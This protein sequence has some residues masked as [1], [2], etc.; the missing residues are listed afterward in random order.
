MIGS[1]K[2]DPGIEPTTFGPGVRTA[3]VD[4]TYCISWKSS[5][6]W[7]AGGSWWTLERIGIGGLDCET[8]RR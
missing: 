8:K 7:G 4:A 5:D 6:T 1:L 3:A 2:V